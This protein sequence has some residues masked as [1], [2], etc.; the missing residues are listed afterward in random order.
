MKIQARTVNCAINTVE[1]KLDL[2]NLEALHEKNRHEKD[3]KIPCKSIFL[4]VSVNHLHSG[5][6]C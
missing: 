6:A 3:R 1:N 5:E 2:E 4:L